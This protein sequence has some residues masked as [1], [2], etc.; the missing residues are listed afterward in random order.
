MTVQ[1]MSPLNINNNFQLAMIMAHD[2]DH[3]IGKDNQLPWKHIKE[4]MDFFKY[5]T[6]GQVV[7]MGRKTFESLGCKP[8]FGRANIVITSN[9][10]PLPENS[11]ATY[12][13]S[14]D[15]ALQVANEFVE[16]SGYFFK[17]V[18]V[19]GGEMV[20]NMFYGTVDTIFVTEVCERF[21]CNTF[22]KI[23]DYLQF[24]GKYHLTEVASSLNVDWNEKGTRL[25]F[26]RFDRV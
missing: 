12:V 15:E 10:E 13:T 17:K 6:Q 14:K 11:G 7:I 4:D 21:D 25:I 9:P 20:Y 3:G 8:L 23:P 22:T 16:K 24:D 18:V 5:I 2:T 26:Q 1:K 19:I